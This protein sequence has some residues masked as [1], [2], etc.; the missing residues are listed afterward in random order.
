MSKSVIIILV[1]IAIV[2]LSAIVLVYRPS[3]LVKSP[4]QTMNVPPTTDPSLKGVLSSSGMVTLEYKGMIFE[5]P[6]ELGTPYLVFAIKAEKIVWEIG[7]DIKAAKSPNDPFKDQ[8]TELSIRDVKENDL[9]IE[10]VEFESLK[11]HIGKPALFITE[12]SA[13]SPLPTT[14]IVDVETGKTIWYLAVN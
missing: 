11:S 3:R 12:T 10:S 8:V 1:L 6:N 13:S 5:A 7:K 2:I 4:D 9:D 14:I